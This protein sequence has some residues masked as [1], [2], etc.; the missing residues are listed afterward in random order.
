MGE[1]ELRPRSDVPRQRE[2]SHW[3]ALL[4]S[5]VERARDVYLRRK[6]T[7]SRLV[8][9]GITL[10]TGAFL[11]AIP[12]AWTWAL[13]LIEAAFERTVSWSV[14]LRQAAEFSGVVAAVGGAFGFGLILAGMWFRRYEH[15]SETSALPHTL[16]PEELRRA[17]ADRAAQVAGDDAIERYLRVAETRHAELDLAGFK[18]RVK[19]PIGL[20]E[21]HVPLHALVN[22]RAIG[23]DEF[24]DSEDAEK[25]LH[26]HAREVALIDA[27]KLALRRGR[28]GLVIL[29]DPGSGKTTHMKRL[30]LACLRAGPSSLGLPPNLLP[31]YL[32]LRELG[33]PEGGLDAVIESELRGPLLDMP[34]GLGRFLLGRGHLLLLFDGLDE[35]PDASKRESVARWIERSAQDRQDCTFVVTSRFAGY[36]ARAQLH[37]AFLELHIRPLTREQAEQFVR[38][39]HDIS[40]RATGEER[41]AA[42]ARAQGLIDRLREPDFRSERIASL[43]RNPLLLANLCIVY[44]YRQDLPR[45]RARLYEECI[46]VL[47]EHWRRGSPGASDELPLA[48]QSRRVLQPAAYWLH[49]VPDRRRASAAELAPVMA[50][51]LSDVQWRGGDADR[52]LGRVRDRSGLLTGWGADSY[53]FMHLGFQEYLAASEIR[54]R[55]G[56]GD[57]SALRE[58]ASNYREPWWQEVILLLLSQP[59]P[60]TFTPFMREVLRSDGFSADSELW[61]L[62]LDEVEEWSLDPF[63]ELLRVRPPWGK[64]MWGRQLEALRVVYA[65]DHALITPLLETFEQHP[66]RAIQD[67][68][69][70]VRAS[71][72]VETELEITHTDPGGVELVR[73]PAGSFWMGSPESEPERSDREGPQREVQ[74]QAFWMGRY[75][76]TNEEYR[77]YLQAHPEAAEPPYW[78]DRR[79]NGP[80]QPVVGV[81]WHEARAFADWCGGRLPTE[82]EWEYACRAGTATPFSFGNQITPSLVNYD[83]NYPYPGG[84][85]AEYRGKT[86][87]VG[88]LPANGF[89]LHEM[90]GNVY[91][92]VEDAYEDSYLEAPSDG[93]AR[94]GPEEASRVLRGGSWSDYA[95]FVR[96]AVRFRSTPD[97]RLISVGFRVARTLP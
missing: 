78:G 3:F 39:W 46:D 64:E 71:R 62:I 53:G 95:Y 69:S 14:D 70:R 84:E 96:S 9:A 12:Q 18:T 83:G 61:T 10:V 37:G 55:T 6:T 56:E 94:C 58:L 17:A 80:R 5:I 27:F 29:G 54:R 13:P 82:A 2:V 38:N 59:N 87:P 86:V 43:I 81:S 91:E 45:E 47:L 57:D 76:V 34:E 93:S 32:P 22:L 60:S 21:L 7:S 75:A 66:S 51:A 74:I 77:R 31:V 44:H 68:L 35:I 26:G 33:D 79:F 36:R 73:I 42:R 50:R 23:D 65:R 90:H 25:H 52:F 40:A 8:G 49:Q 20:E 72:Q 19:V 1:R 67:W 88:T 30:L 97:G 28:R 89:G 16:D 41:G 85:K 4:R 24:G 15:L 63:L 48:P 11:A 92:W